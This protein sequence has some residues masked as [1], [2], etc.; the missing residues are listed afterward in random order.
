MTEKIIYRHVHIRL[1]GYVDSESIHFPYTGNLFLIL[2]LIGGVVM[3]SAY[4]MS[5]KLSITQRRRECLTLRGEIAL[6]HAKKWFQRGKKK[7]YV[8]N[9]FFK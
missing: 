5:L 4:T 7:E 6:F 9:S 3:K 2:L 1:L 8:L